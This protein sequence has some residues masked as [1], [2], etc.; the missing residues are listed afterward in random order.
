MKTDAYERV[1]PALDPDL[2]VVANAREATGPPRSEYTDDTLN[3]ALRNA[4]PASV[5]ELGAGGREVVIIETLPT[6][7]DRDFD[8]RLCLETAEWVEE[9][10]FVANPT[11]DWHTKLNAMLRSPR[12]P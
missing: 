3:A 10:R 11:L 1:I 8:P 9:C 5:E 4:T 6:P 12:H 7:A 2:V